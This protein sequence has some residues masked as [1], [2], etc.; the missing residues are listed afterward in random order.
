MTPG[1]QSEVWG[2]SRELWSKRTFERLPGAVVDP[3]GGGV[4]PRKALSRVI[5]MVK[6]VGM[7][8][9]SSFRRNDEA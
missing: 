4:V 8:T 1:P 9:K 2:A 3:R 5:T 7:R 6:V